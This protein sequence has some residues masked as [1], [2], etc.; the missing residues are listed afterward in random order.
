MEQTVYIDL[1]FI[2]NFSMDFLCFFLSSSLLTQKMH[3][4]RVILASLIGGAYA[5]AALFIPIAGV[6]GVLLDIAA[7]VV[8]SAVAVK[9]K[10]NGK[11][12]WVY[13]LVF[14][15][16]SILL[17]GF[18]TVLFSFF[19]KIGLDRLLGS[20]GD[21]DG[22]SV[23]LFALLA[24]L[25]GLISFLGGKFFKKK[26]GRQSC[27]LELT[28]GQKSIELSALCDSGNLLTDPITSKP[29]IVVDISSAAS[30]LPEDILYFIRSGGVKATAA[31]MKIRVIPTRTVSGSGILYAIRFDKIRI[32]MGKG[33]SEIDAL[34]AFSDIKGSA[35]EAQALVP[36]VFAL[37]AP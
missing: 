31:N 5:C 32:N 3:V 36:S 6:G 9:K 21:S 30:I 1:F 10:G 29:C 16:C 17:G 34:V 26:A 19:N 18:M 8:M 20:E 2:I 22:V 13:S 11:E 12:V 33:W 24:V 23:W 35:E 25:G 14:T 28:F 4:W 37:G 27:K 7:C 15:A